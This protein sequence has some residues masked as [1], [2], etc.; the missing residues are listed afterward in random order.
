MKISGSNRGVNTKSSQNGVNTNK[1]S[2][3]G[4]NTKSSQNGV[5]TKISRNGVNTNFKSGNKPAKNKK[6]P[7]MYSKS[8]SKVSTSTV[9][10]I[11]HNG[12]KVH[13]KCQYCKY[14]NSLYAKDNGQLISQEIFRHLMFCHH[15]SICRLKVPAKKIKHK[16]ESNSM[17]YWSN[18]LQI[19]LLLW[20]CQ[21]TAAIN[22]EQF[23]IKCHPI[24]QVTELQDTIDNLESVRPFLKSLT[25]PQQNILIIHGQP[26]V[27]VNQQI[28]AERSVSNYSKVMSEIC[29]RSALLTYE[30]D[31]RDLLLLSRA[32]QQ[33]D[34]SEFVMIGVVV[35]GEMTYRSSKKYSFFSALAPAHS[36]EQQIYAIVTNVKGLISRLIPDK[37]DF[38]DYKVS[39]CTDSTAG[40]LTQ[41]IALYKNVQLFSTEYG[42]L[43]D[44]SIVQIKDLI[45]QTRTDIEDQDNCRSSYLEADI[46][47]PSLLNLENVFKNMDNQFPDLSH[48]VTSDSSGLEEAQLEFQALQEYMADLPNKLFNLKELY[49]LPGPDGSLIDANFWSDLADGQLGEILLLVVILGAL[50][51]VVGTLCY[52]KKIGVIAFLICCCQMFLSPMS[53]VP[54]ILNR[55]RAQN[56]ILVPNNDL[57]M[58][59]MRG[60]ALNQ[61]CQ[62]LNMRREERRNRLLQLI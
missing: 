40:T 41:M 35:G 31:P 24:F 62:N 44:S 55:A 21:S 17:F 13:W 23:E 32:L 15:T 47:F 51:L 33:A 26:V 58:M 38:T 52:C 30:P 10:P 19:L 37:I 29:F 16:T 9:N 36:R 14:E 2:Q 43:I 28:I 39:F 3:H 48:T 20:L 7:L 25:F 54:R 34:I 46:S 50:C 42:A 56:R 57:Q 59:Q 49:E 53:L 61:E 45:N 6:S 8:F 1:S 18:F 27:V 22:G 12:N 11:F 4:V 5:N 60:R